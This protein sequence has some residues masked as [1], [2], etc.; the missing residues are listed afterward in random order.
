MNSKQLAASAALTALLLGCAG[1]VG[2]GH[3]SDNTSASGQAIIARESSDGSG[4][5]DVNINFP[6]PPPVMPGTTQADIDYVFDVRNVGTSP[7]TIKR[8]SISSAA[9]TY[10]LE[11]WSRNYKKTIAPG[12]TE[13]LNFVARAV[14]INDNFGLRGPITVRAEV[15]FENADGVQRSAFVRNL[16]GDISV[17]MTRRP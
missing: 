14:Q 3:D 15:E 2:V 7:A 5:L 8:I 6:D 13:K 9:G 11:R 4:A 1:A 12:E 17:G 10:Q 16:G